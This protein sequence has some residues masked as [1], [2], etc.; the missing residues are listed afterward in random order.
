[1]DLR[2]TIP[3]PGRYS[4]DSRSYSSSS[5]DATMEDATMATA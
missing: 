1:M 2:R 5:S 3:T 4:G